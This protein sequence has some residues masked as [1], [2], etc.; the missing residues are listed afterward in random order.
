MSG[1]TESSSVGQSA[2]DLDEKNILPNNG[3]TPSPESEKDSIGKK[4]GSVSV[5]SEPSSEAPSANVF[6]DP[7]VAAHWKAVYEKSR[8]ECRAVF[9]PEFTWTPEEEKKLVW[10]LDWHGKPHIEKKSTFIKQ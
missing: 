5:H 7:E 10:K 8:Y 4:D 9:D 1:N 6:S 2:S 3:P